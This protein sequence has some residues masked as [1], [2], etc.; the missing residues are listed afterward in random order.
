HRELAPISDAAWADIEEETTR[1]LKRY[2]A[3]RRVVDVHGPGGV[4]LS[5][6][7][8]GHLKTVAEPGE[9]ILASQ[10]EVKTLVA[11][12]VA[13][14]LDR[15]QVDVI[16]DGANGC[17]WHRAKNAAKKIAYVEDRAIFEGYSAAGIGGIRQGTS[18]PIITL[19]ADVRQY[20]DAIAQALKQLRLV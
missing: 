19:P 2:L 6:V 9:G 17:D 16:G 14:E 5:A 12:R 13:F 11:L 4:G 8:T 3:G 1:T 15:L 20:P 18:N 10:R 7:G